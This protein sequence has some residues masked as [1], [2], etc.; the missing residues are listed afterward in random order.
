MFLGGDTS[1]E[2][3]R[4]GNDVLQEGHGCPICSA[5]TAALKRGI[6][7]LLTVSPDLA[8]QWH[9]MKNGN[10]K[11]SDVTA[12]SMRKVWW[13]CRK[14]HEWEAS[15]NGRQK[16][17]GCPY[18]SGNRILPGC[19]DLLSINAPFLSEWDYEKNG[20]LKPESFGRGSIRK[21]WWK[22]REGHSWE[23]AIYS[24]TAGSGCP[25]CAGRKVLSGFNDLASGCPEITR[26]WDYEKN[27]SLHPED[28]TAGSNK[29]VWWRCGE[30]HSWRT[31]VADRTIGGN[32]CPYC[33]NRKVWPG[34]NDLL[35]RMPKIACEWDGLKN[36]RLQPDE[37]TFRTGRLIWWRCGKGHSYRMSVYNRWKG[38]GCPYCGGTKVLSGFNDLRTVTPWIAEEWDDERNG[39]L[40]PEHVFPYTN[41]KVWWKCENGHHW[42]ST[43]NSRQKGAGYPYCH[44]LIPRTPHFIS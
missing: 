1:H 23:A 36:G 6:N 34:F 25:Y 38:K 28:I 19:T 42:K 40:K 24:R 13:Q 32:S 39:N 20:D 2:R 10:L 4:G 3:Q 12:H 33:G 44:G 31:S 27:G 7:D 5:R 14:G 26:E 30:G 17:R 41:R 22:C 21:V 35:S 37:V 8:A 29:R 16:G 15:V 9:D 11:P 43:I 18:C